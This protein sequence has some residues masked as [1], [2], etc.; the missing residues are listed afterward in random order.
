MF[1]VIAVWGAVGKVGKKNKGKLVINILDSIKSY[2]ILGF[3]TI[4]F[5]YLLNMACN[6]SADE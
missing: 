2:Y 1:G 3:L 6:T 5:H 4:S